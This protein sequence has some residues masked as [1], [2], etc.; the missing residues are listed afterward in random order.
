VSP[1]S[2]PSLSWPKA[3]SPTPMC[4]LC[5]RA[6]IKLLV[7]QAMPRSLKTCFCCCRVPGV[8][9]LCGT[10]DDASN[11]YL[12]FEPCFGGD[13]YKRLAHRGLYEEAQLCKEVRI[14]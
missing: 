9:D 3:N 2:R 14:L 12:V 6:P 10:A 5:Q 8:V 7:H 13:L 1:A 11:I 4:R